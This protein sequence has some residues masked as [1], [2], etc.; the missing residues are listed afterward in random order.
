MS[1]WLAPPVLQELI[2]LR[3]AKLHVTNVQYELRHCLTGVKESQELE[4]SKDGFQS[5]GCE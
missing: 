1:H 5:S 2:T 4:V 3:S